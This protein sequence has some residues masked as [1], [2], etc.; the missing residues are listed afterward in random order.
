[1]SYSVLLIVTDIYLILKRERKRDVSS[2]EK[3]FPSKLKFSHVSMSKWVMESIFILIK[4]KIMHLTYR[5]KI[6]I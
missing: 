6:K 4:K 2:L 1:M 3:Y 5:I